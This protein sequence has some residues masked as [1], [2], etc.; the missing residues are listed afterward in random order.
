MALAEKI[1][2]LENHII[3]LEQDA[4]L[5]PDQFSYRVGFEEGWTAAHENAP[6]GHARANWKDPNFGTPEYAGE[7]QCEFCTELGVLT[8]KIHPTPPGWKAAWAFYKRMR[9]HHD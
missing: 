1:E 4:R 6:C 9:T 8:G 7:E 2:G 5:P 3:A